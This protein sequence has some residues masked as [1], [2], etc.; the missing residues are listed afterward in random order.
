MANLSTET[1]YCYYFWY[2]RDDNED[3]CANLLDY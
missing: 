1:L 3:G 2:L